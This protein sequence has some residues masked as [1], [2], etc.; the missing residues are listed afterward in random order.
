MVFAGRLTG[1]EFTPRNETPAPVPLPAITNLLQV[2]QLGMQ[3]SCISHPIRLEGQVCWVNPEQK[4]FAML[5][6][7]GGLI[8]EMEWLN[9]SLSIGQRVRLTG[10]ATVRRAGNTVRV[11]VDGLVVDDD[12]L[13]PMIERTG[14]VFLKA[15]KIPIRVEW[16]NGTGPF[17]LEVSWEGPDLPRWRIADSGLFRNPGETTNRGSGLDYRCYEGWWSELPD[18]TRLKPVKIGMVG[19]FDL[20][21][22]TRDEGVGL[23]FTGLFEVPRD[24]IYKFYLN[25]DDGSRLSIGEPNA[26]VEIIGQGQLPVPRH[27]LIGQLLDETEDGSWSQIE[28][29]VTKVWPAKEGLRMELSVGLA[30]MEVRVSEAAGL[31]ETTLMNS[32]IRATGF[33]Q[34]AC[35]SDGL[36]VPNLLLVPGSRLIEIVAPSTAAG[37]T[38][39]NPAGL[40]VLTTAVEVHHL[41][42]AEAQMGYTAKVRGVV[43]SIDPAPPG[44][45]L[46]DST[47]GVYVQGAGPV[48]VGEFVEVE[49][50]TDPGEF[51]PMLRLS[52]FSRIGEGRLPEPIHPAWDQLMNG[53]LDAQ[54]VEL[55]GIVTTVTGDGVKLLT[56]GGIIKARLLFGLNLEDMKRYENTLVQIRGGLLADWNAQTHQ[57]M[58]GGVRIFNPKVTAKN[59]SPADGF[60]APYKTPADLLLFDP[61][62]SLFQRVRMSGQI[63]HVGEEV[64]FMMAGTNGVRFVANTPGALR[65]GDRVDVA[66]YPQLGGASPLLREAVVRKTGHATLP[67][68]RLLSPGNLASAK[69]DSTHVRVEGVLTGVREAGVETVL[70]MQDG[71]QNFVARLNGGHE[72]L[73]SLPAGCRLE[74]TGVYAVQDGNQVLDHPISSFELL[75]NSPADVKVLARPPWWTLRRLLVAV[76]M[77]ACVLMIA[78]LWITQLHRKIEERTAQLEEQI[79]KR[80]SIEQ[81]RVMEQERARIAQ[82]LHDE[83]GSSLT[84]IGMLAAGPVATTDS[85]RHLDQIGDRARRM[86]AALDEIVWAMNPEHDSLESLGSYLC[87]YADRFLKLANITFRLTGTLDLPNQTLNSVHRHEFFLAFKEAL[88]NVVRHSGA[89][90]VRIS[91]R[92]IGN[93]LR[94]SL[95][96]DGGGLGSGPP[97]AGMDG[98]SNMRARMEKMGGRFAIA[99]EAGRGT[100]LRFYLPLN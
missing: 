29:K 97:T 78:V 74:L 35:N 47:G 95:A 42:R 80:Q 8:L 11:G 27:M 93:R 82:D 58:L 54:Y 65:V 24:G 43:T 83:L 15:G 32:L 16:F 71:A 77:L 19:N 84:E 66:G 18:F 9:Q 73:R 23:Q 86:V 38:N 98:L 28:G 34:G 61:Q 96:D 62:A 46:Q 13:H 70:E 55:E 99:S 51:A 94:L 14:A 68:A 91:I 1:A 37:V 44:F 48:R 17:G 50:E 92:I 31:S 39:K 59:S 45:T 26:H 64:C 69:C 76:G 85:L 41:T 36:K 87:L 72:F 81:H 89:T 57:V 2:R 53:S 100:T 40:P 75:L 63:V 52:Q 88:T 5:D 33:C 56:H 4:A 22:R 90:E 25:S 12:A 49:G 60:T 67:E 21:V 10:A 3:N 6:A 20:G 30:R 7:S 79:Q